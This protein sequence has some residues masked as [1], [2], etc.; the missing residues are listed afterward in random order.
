MLEL[1]VILD[2]A[3][4]SCGHDMGV[5]LKCAG[6]GLAVGGQGLAAVKVPCPTCS[7]LNEIVFEPTSGNLHHV[8]PVWNIGLVPEP[9]LN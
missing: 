2:F 6:S 5:T 1:E 9:S 3:C 7:Q 4:T 8:S